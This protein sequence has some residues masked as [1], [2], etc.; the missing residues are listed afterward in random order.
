MDY[1]AS[2]ILFSISN[3]E[4]QPLAPPTKDEIKKY[5]NWWNSL[6]EAWKQA[7]NEAFLNNSDTKFPPDETLHLIWNTGP[8]RFAGPS[9][10]FPN[11]TFELEDLSGVTALT[12]VEILVV[13]NH[14]IGSLKEIAHMTWL[15]SLFVFSN[16]L[17]SLEGVE[18]LKNLKNLYFN[19][20]RIESLQPLAGLTQLETIHCSRNK[21]SSFDGLGLQHKPA[22]ENLYCLP[23]DN[24]FTADVI[25]F[26]GRMRI[27]C[28]KG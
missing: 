6:S 12:N 25:E 8:L 20:N 18:N 15:K 5:R 7:F 10:M 11:T 13:S 2:N 14:K 19:D 28:Q 21:I 4:N 1:C 24:L 27:K 23:N 26:E 22:L 16:S 17:T 9:A 3:M